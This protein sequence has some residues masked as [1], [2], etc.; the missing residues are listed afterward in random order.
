MPIRHRQASVE[1]NSLEH[2]LVKLLIKRVRLASR[3]TRITRMSTSEI[4]C[5]FAPIRVL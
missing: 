4:L 5:V 3:S 1:E 2:T